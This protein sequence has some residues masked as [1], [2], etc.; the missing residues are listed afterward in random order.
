MSRMDESVDAP[1]FQRF[2]ELAWHDA[3]RWAAALTGDVASGE[4]IAQEAF[5]AVAGR[6]SQLDNPAGYLRRAIVNG[7]RM[8]HRSGSRR[9]AR[10]HSVAS[11][12]VPTQPA[13]VDGELLDVLACLPYDQ[14]A[15]V[16][17]RY[18]A[19]WTDES[20]AVAL[21]CRPST[22]RS[23]LRRGLRRLRDDLTPRD[24]T[25]ESAP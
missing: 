22:V 13:S 10:E 16:V 15:A 25:G 23:H 5:L 7:A 17:L 11:P 6:Y 12:N 9:V 1:A 18:W 3:A 2:Y 21:D 24:P 19:D 20:I 4:E 14:R 8:W